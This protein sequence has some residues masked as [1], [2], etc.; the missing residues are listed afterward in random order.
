[1]SSSAPEVPTGTVRVPPDESFWQ[2][3]SP[4]HEAPLSGVGSFALHFFAIGFLVMCGYLGWLGFAPRPARPTVDIRVESDGGPEA[5]LGRPDGDPTSRHEAA[6]AGPPSAE[7]APDDRPSAPALPDVAPAQ[8]PDLKPLPERPV[9][10]GDVKGMMQSLRGIPGA[11][12]NKGKSAPVGSPHGSPT[13]TGT[14]D[15]PTGGLSGD[16]LPRTQRWDLNF[17]TL[18]PRDYLRQLQGLGAILIIPTGPDGSTKVIRDLS[19]RPAQLLD[20][21]VGQIPGLCWREIDPRAVEGVARELGLKFRPEYFGAFMPPELEEK[22]ARLERE[23][24]G[25]KEGQIALT[26]FR[27][28]RIGNKYDVRVIAQE[29]LR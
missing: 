25:R 20:E 6:D 28:E 1:M 4:H 19:R 12:E 16:P 22:L 7:S 15:R 27:V 11:S 10:A 26:R 2:H 29:P 8:T 5:R 21:D 3:Y 14:K 13:G 9:F 17:S 23:Y 18:D 24:A